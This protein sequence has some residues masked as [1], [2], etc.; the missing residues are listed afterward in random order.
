MCV[1]WQT[2]GAMNCTSHG[3]ILLRSFGRFSLQL[4]DDIIGELAPLAPEDILFINWG[5]W[6][7]RFYIAGGREEFG[8]WKADMEEVILQRLVH[9]KSRV[10]WKGY[11]SFHYAGET[12]AFTG[13]RLRLQACCLQ[14]VCLH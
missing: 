5:A 11:T 7:H 2:V 3:Q 6:Y 8:A 4:W 10:I 12:G 1:G 9:I 14:E 13:V